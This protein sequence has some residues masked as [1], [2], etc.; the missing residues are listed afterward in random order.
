MKCPAV[1]HHVEERGQRA[2]PVKLVEGEVDHGSQHPAAIESREDA[3][4]APAVEVLQ[5]NPSR[6]LVFSEKDGGDQ[7]AAEHEEDHHSEPT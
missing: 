3:K 6:S 4:G 5:R 2:F 7:K 1:I